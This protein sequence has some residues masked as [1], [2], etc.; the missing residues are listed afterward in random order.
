MPTTAPA[1]TMTL[2]EL[3]DAISNYDG[4][5]ARLRELLNHAHEHGVTHV[6]VGNA[7]THVP[8]KLHVPKKAPRA[9]FTRAVRKTWPPHTSAP[10]P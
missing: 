7:F 2:V 4:T 10:S 1:M 3:Q 5:L 8:V 6:R 9:A